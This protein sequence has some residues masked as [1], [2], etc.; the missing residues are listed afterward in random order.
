MVLG[1]SPD[2]TVFLCLAA[3]CS[4]ISGFL[5]YQEVGKV[6]RKL[7]EDEQILYLF[8]RYPRQMAKNKTQYKRF[9]PTGRVDFLAIRTGNCSLG[10]LG[11]HSNF[12]SFVQIK[13]P[14]GC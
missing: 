10:L 3:S 2:A 1:M 8:I 13:E 14:L 5:T 9:Y 7:S 4:I 11:C 6:N 12:S